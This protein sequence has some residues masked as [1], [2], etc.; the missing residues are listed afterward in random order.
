MIEYLTLNYEQIFVYALALLGF[1]AI[2]AKFTPTPKDDA[3]LGFL[4]DLIS[5]VTPNDRVKSVE[6]KLD[7]VEEIADQVEDI[8]DKIKDVKDDSK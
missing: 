2:I 1:L 6:D 7:V 3:I 5:K 8:V 4:Y